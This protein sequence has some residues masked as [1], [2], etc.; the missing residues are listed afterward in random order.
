MAVYELFVDGAA[1]GQGQEKMGVASCG[2]VIKKNGKTIG[3]YA[4][5]LGRRTNNEAEYEA[6]LHGVLMCWAADL[7]DP[8]IYSDSTLVVNQINGQWQCK[9]E[10][11]LPLLLSVLEIQEEFRFRI[12]HVPRK[13]VNEADRLANQFLDKLLTNGNQNLHQM[14]TRKAPL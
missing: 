9:N 1:R 7:Q 13:Y 2:I 14:Q 10:S 12:Q 8:I 11:L 3:Q 4:R 6:V 5:G